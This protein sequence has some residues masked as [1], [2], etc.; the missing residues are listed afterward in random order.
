WTRFYYRTTNFTYDSDGTK[1]FRNGDMFLPVYPDGWWGTKWGGRQ[2]HFEGRN[3][4]E[5]CPDGSSDGYAS[6]NYPA[7]MAS[8]DLNDDNWYCI[9]THVQLNTP[10]IADGA[11]EAFVDGAQVMGYYN[12]LFRGS[13]PNGPN[14]NSSLATFSYVRIYTQFGSGFLY[15]DDF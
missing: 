8:I 13:D 7:N 9:E 1:W 12:R 5:M 10:G 15:Y 3:V 4:A 6:C 14:D 11:L 2:V